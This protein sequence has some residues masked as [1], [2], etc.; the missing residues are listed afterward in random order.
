M[1]LDRDS[2]GLPVLVLWRFLTRLPAFLD[3]LALSTGLVGQWNLVG[4]VP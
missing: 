1:C 2:V 3:R 4:L